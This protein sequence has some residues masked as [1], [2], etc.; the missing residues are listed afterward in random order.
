MSQQRSTAG[1]RR[2]DAQG[3]GWARVALAAGLIAVVAV[4]LRDDTRPPAPDPQHA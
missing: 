2:G 1:G 3:S 4:G